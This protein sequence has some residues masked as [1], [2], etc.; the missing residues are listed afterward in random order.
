MQ[1]PL[2][3]TFVVLIVWSLINITV[4]LR[5]WGHRVYVAPHDPRQPVMVSPVERA[6]ILASMRQYTRSLH[7]VLVGARMGD[8]AA[9]RVG[10][11]SSGA[12]SA[13]AIEFSDNL[14]MPYRRLSRATHSSFD[15]LAARAAFGPDSV[16]AAVSRVTGTCVACH[17]A[18]RL[19][20]W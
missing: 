2:G 13:M 14:P 5:L 12:Q 4:S 10:A 19:G 8:S 16:F 9:V 18:Y 6:A 17:T 15:S 3:I 7:E 11:T 1:K 20:Q